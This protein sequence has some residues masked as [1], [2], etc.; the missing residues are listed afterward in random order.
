MNWTWF[1]VQELP[2]EVYDVLM[3]MLTK[4]QKKDQA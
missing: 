4:E 3:D 1:D 2:V